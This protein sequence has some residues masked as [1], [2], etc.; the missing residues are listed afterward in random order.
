[1]LSSADIEDADMCIMFS[2]AFIPI[3][4]RSQCADRSMIS[5]KDN[6]SVLSSTIT[7]EIV[8]AEPSIVLAH[9]VS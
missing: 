9:L 6:K 7:P 1:M 5:R 8:F 3:Y 2:F 4:S